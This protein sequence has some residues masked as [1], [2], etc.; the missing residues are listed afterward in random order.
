MLDA[1]PKTANT[2]P[3]KEAVT[4]QQK[5]M[6]FYDKDRTLMTPLQNLEQSY[7]PLDS[8]SPENKSLEVSDTRK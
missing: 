7:M 8:S 4:V 2:L 6:P 3:S 1:V 5:Q